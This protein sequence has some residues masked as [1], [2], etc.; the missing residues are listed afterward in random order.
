VTPENKDPVAQRIYTYVSEAGHSGQEKD[1]FLSELAGR[2]KVD[3]EDLISRR[4]LQLMNPD[5]L[6][7]VAAQGFDIQLHTHRHRMP[8]GKDLFVKEIEDNRRA[9][10]LD[11]KNSGVLRHFCY[12]SGVY[13]AQSGE[14]LRQCGVL[15]ATTC[16]PGL[17]KQ[18]SDPYYLPRFCDSMNIHDVVFEGWVSG[19]A[20][21]VPHTRR[22]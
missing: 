6:R 12:P 13:Y 5:E 3:Y 19:A 18:S 11:G 9:L 4:I 8:P 1:A 2:L 16:D 21:L 10:D 15:S 14:L 22:K 20:A 17:A 7:E